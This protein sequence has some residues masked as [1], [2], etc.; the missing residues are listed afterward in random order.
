[1][2]LIIRFVLSVPALVILVS[3]K[4]WPERPAGYHRHTVVTR[5]MLARRYVLRPAPSLV[6][7]GRRC[8]FLNGWLGRAR[9]TTPARMNP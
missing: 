9:A 5:S 4:A 2:S 8:L 3:Q 1:M 6:P 7:N